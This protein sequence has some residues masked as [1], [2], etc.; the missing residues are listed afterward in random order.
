METR[1]S[2]LLVG[3]FVLVLVA[4]T[5]GFLVWLIN[6]GDSG[7]KQ[8]YDIV[9][10]GSVTGLRDG[11]AVRMNGVT[12]GD[13]VSVALEPKDPSKVRIGI[14]V[15]K[16][17]PINADTRATLELE[18]LTGGRYLLLT[19]GT[20]S[21]PPLQ[22]TAGEPYPIIVAEPSALDQVLEDVPQILAKATELLTRGN[23]LLS[24][25]NLAN[26]SKAFANIASATE[27]FT[28]G[29]D[30]M[31]KM[32]ENLNVTLDAVKGAA[33]AVQVFFGDETKAL[34]ASADQLMQRGSD[35]LSDANI[36]A[37][38]RAIENFAVLSDSLAGSRDQIQQILKNV[39]DA[40]ADLRGV[41]QSMKELVGVIQ[42]STPEFVDNAN[43]LLQRGNRL[44]SDENLESLS[45]TFDSLA[46]LSD[47]LAANRA[48]LE[49]ILVNVDGAL[50]SVRNA[51]NSIS[52]FTTD[53]QGSAEDL[54]S[55]ADETFKQIGGLA[56]SVNTALSRIDEDVQV[57]VRKV[58]EGVDSFSRTS[59]EI[60]KMVAENREPLRDFTAQ[61]LFELVNFLVEA[62]ELVANLRTMTTNV[63]RDPARFFFGNQQEGYEPSR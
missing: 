39:D 9:Y 27:A 58:G 49:S 7:P 25:D 12:V 56:E 20:A 57:V 52:S 44:L 30:G 8:R 47:A 23:E 40:I 14:E 17:A 13:V 36:Q 55:T 50:E 31:G 41:A 11:S 26:V 32:F 37:A 43:Q 16:S 18:G 62:R 29:S 15:L 54:L 46:V 33:S 53:V 61:G 28:G 34:V 6:A 51:A 38:S 60:G 63:E 59:D 19:G 22:P 24:D 4:G 1:A 10:A 3:G 45:Q 48:R 5:L 2:Y 42:E 35:L 21:S